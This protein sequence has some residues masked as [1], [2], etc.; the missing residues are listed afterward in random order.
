M[1]HVMESSKHRNLSD[2]VTKFLRQEPASDA[3]I[4]SESFAEYVRCVDKTYFIGAQSLESGGAISS[5]Q[6]EDPTI[7]CSEVRK[8][9]PHGQYNIVGSKLN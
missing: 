9:S 8:N 7:M 4:H 1:R 3:W 6:I 5:E 2:L